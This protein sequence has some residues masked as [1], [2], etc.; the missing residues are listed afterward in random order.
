MS[1]WIAVVNPLRGHKRHRVY[2][3]SAILAIVN[4]RVRVVF[5]T[6]IK[7]L[8]EHI[9]DFFFQQAEEPSLYIKEVIENRYISKN[10]SEVS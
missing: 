10:L 5:A 3:E 9:Y 2:A 1:D 6:K 7:Q 8:K 4:I